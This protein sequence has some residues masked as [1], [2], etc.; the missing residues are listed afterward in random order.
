MTRK[1]VRGSLLAIILLLSS[2][3]QAC[4]GGGTSE[5][6]ESGSGEKVKIKWATW[7]NP[8][9]LSRFQELTKEFNKNH[10]D[11]EVEFIPIPGEYDQ[12]ILTQLTGGTA[13]D[14]FYAGD[15]LVVK[16]I[17]NQSIE[18]LTTYMEAPESVIKKEDYFEGLWGAAVRDDQ[19]FGVPVDCNP[20]VL[21][22]NKKVLKEAGITEMPADLQANGQ[23]TWDKFKE[24]ADKIRDSKKYGYVLDNSWN[25][26]HSWVT[27][28]GGRVYD[29]EGNFVAASDPKAMEAFRF[30]YDNVKSKNITFSGTLPKGQGGDAMFMSNQV[31]FVAAGRWYLPL[32]KKNQGLEYDVVTWPTNTGNKIEPAGIPTA[33]MVMNKASKNKEAAYTFFSEYVSKE[34]QRFRLQGGGNAVPSVQ[35]TDEVVLEGNLPEHAQ[36]FLDAREIG[37]SLTPFEAGIPGLSQDITSKFEA[38]WLKDQELESSLKDIQDMAN[39]KI[40]DYKSGNN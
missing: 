9:E 32:F 25:S 34:G 40:Q 18:N 8:G 35:G 6:G 28:N 13:P 3:L 23:W 4:G 20:M 21:W 11:I 31:G 30:L 7:G 38:L 33:Y 22:Y 36:L 2:I 29:D 26:Y 39:K 24:M 1:Q 12:K 17:E 5:G 15:A 37:Y 14:I 16:L 27:S 10:S 19:I